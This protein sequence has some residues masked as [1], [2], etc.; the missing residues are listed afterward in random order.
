M[1]HA[2]GCECV[3]TERSAGGGRQD[4]ALGGAVG[5]LGV[6][7]E[8]LCEC[9]PFQ[10]RRCVPGVKEGSGTSPQ[11][12]AWGPGHSLSEATP[13]PEPSPRPDPRTCGPDFEA[14]SLAC[15]LSG[16][17]IPHLCAPAPFP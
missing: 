6:C 17:G 2:G 5:S 7:F 10:S 8:F 11:L 14:R 4:F 16:H 1:P 3:F 13:P 12:S 15:A 9:V